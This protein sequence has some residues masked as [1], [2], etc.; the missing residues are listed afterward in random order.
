M[1]V[2]WLAEATATEA[3][4]AELA[5]ATQGRPGLVVHLHGPLGAGKTTLV[6]GWLRALGVT[7]TIR[8]P[9]Y[10]LVEPYRADGREILHLDLYRLRDPAELEG[11]ALDDSPPSRTLW[12]VEWPEQGGDRLPLADL[13]IRLQVDENGRTAELHWQK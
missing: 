12:L 7:G 2:L 11:L 8:S 3:L 5:L 13:V 9:T 4:G 6:R 1:T 10:T